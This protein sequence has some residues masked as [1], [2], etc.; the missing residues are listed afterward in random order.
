MGIVE[1]RRGFFKRDAMLLIVLQG[2]D[3]IPLEERTATY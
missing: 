3:G 2:L 1:D